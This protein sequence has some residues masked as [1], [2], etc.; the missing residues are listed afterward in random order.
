MLSAREPSVLK[1]VEK[2]VQSFRASSGAWL[3]I[4]LKI[5]AAESLLASGLRRKSKAFAR[6][7]YRGAVERFFAPSAGTD[8][9]EL[10][11][12]VLATLLEAE[13]IAYEATTYAAL[14]ADAALRER[15]LGS[16]DC[17]FAS[18]TLL[19]DLSELAPMVALLKR[20][21]NHVVAGGALGGI[22]HHT[23]SHVPG[24]E[25]LAVGYGEL[26][27]ASLA[28]WMRSG[29]REIVP[30]PGGR[31]TRVAETSILYSGVPA[32]KDLD[33]L[34][35]PD[36]SLAERLH[37]RSFSMVHY[38]SVRGCPY[39]CSFCNYPFLFDDTK[40]RYR[41]AAR[42]AADWKMLADRGVRFVSCLDS[43]FT[44]PKRRLVEL[45][46]RLI[47]DGTKIRWICYARADDLEDLE[48]CRLMK[49]AGCHQVQIGVESGNQAQL[50][51]MNKRTTVRANQ[52][53]LRNCRAV[54]I[55]SLATVIVGFPGETRATLDDSF[56]CLQDSPPDVYYLAPFNTRV[57]YVPILQPD[58]RAR[59]GIVTQTDGRSSAPYW[60]H[61]SMSCTEIGA[62]ARRI[63]RR[64]ADERVALEGTLFYAGLLGFDARDREA[65]LD[66][67][68]DVWTGMP[69]LR[70]T[71]DRLGAWA[72]KKLEADVE[73]VLCGETPPAPTA[74]PP[75]GPSIRR[76]SRRK[77]LP[78]AGRE[79]S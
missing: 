71:M 34:P 1:A 2:Q 68:R 33:F 72:Q 10:T 27:V 48:T 61:A 6:A 35:T 53:A 11:E 40:F 37:G 32:T 56:A 31:L 26:L 28:A 67:Q 62:H 51:N 63:H 50:D 47:K 59:F 17:V 76:G 3:D 7:P 55:T 22:L 52:T 42:I 18:T 24:L 29:Y 73:R 16:C 69:L 65:L 13:G 58:S 57:E 12:V 14:H 46:E 41:S 45:C 23:W 19:R 54:G 78:L 79:A 44:M 43:L 9:P 25:V 75:R 8:P 20:P 30:P 64:M 39:R 49:A 15:L 38:E 4:Q 60:K 77:E 70:L 74:D 5:L 36:W 66:F 21:H